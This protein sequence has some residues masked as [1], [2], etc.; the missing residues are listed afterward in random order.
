MIRCI[1]TITVAAFLTLV[2]V[3][4]V[5][6]P[7]GCTDQTHSASTSDDALPNDSLHT[8]VLC[9]LGV[10]PAVSAPQLE[11]LALVGTSLP[12]LTPSVR[13]APPPLPYHPPRL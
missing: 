1:A 3:D 5:C 8:C 2:A 9:V 6:C 13:L 4:Q 12:A 7:D 10:E 11:P